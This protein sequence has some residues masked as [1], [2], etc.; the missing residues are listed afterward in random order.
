VDNEDGVVLDY[1]LQQGNP[2]GAPQPA[3]AITRIAARTG[4]VW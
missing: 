4:Q 2:T 3:P 1:D